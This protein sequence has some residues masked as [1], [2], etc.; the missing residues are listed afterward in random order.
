MPFVIEMYKI[1][2]NIDRIV[3]YFGKIVWNRQ[4]SPRKK[5]SANRFLYDI[6]KRVLT[7][8]FYFIRRLL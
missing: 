7:D 8:G 5:M 2:G 3:L 1:N 4:E 6:I